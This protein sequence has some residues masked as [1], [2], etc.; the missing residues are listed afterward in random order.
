[1]DSRNPRG[2]GR[3]RR[4]KIINNTEQQRAIDDKNTPSLHAD[5]KKPTAIR[6]AYDDQQGANSCTSLY[7]IRQK[8]WVV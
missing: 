3:K 1:M 5:L 7:K 8:S 6:E 4:I 2:A